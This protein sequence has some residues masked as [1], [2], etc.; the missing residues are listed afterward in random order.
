MKEIELSTFL[1]IVEMVSNSIFLQPVISPI[2]TIDS[3]ESQLS[4][5]TPSY[6]PFS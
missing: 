6:E 3:Q 1:S 4:R 5:E 2:D